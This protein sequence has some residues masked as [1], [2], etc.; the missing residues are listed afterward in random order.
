MNIIL[1][2][3]I[4]LIGFFGLAAFSDCPDVKVTCKN[5]KT[6]E[7]KESPIPTAGACWNWTTLI[8]EVCD[9]NRLAKACV[10]KYGSDW[11]G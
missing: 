4:A 2:V 3:F 8:C 10:D 5:I 1:T 11:N 6:G 9:P 7:V